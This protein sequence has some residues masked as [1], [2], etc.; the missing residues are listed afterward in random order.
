MHKPHFFLALTMVH[1]PIGEIIL[2]LLCLWLGFMD[3]TQFL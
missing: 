3:R 1:P 2:Q